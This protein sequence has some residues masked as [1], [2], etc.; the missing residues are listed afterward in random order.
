[1]KIYITSKIYLD[2]F[3]IPQFFLAIFSTYPQTP[4]ADLRT[5][6]VTRVENRCSI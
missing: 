6:R 5:L 4:A 2:D 3:F 1:M